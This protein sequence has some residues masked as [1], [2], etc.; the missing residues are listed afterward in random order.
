ML[1]IQ[2]WSCLLGQKSDTGNCF[3]VL[4]ANSLERAKEAALSGGR[5]E[6]S[7]V[8]KPEVRNV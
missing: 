5:S 3:S 2:R 4:P 6:N 1:K 8:F 7:Q